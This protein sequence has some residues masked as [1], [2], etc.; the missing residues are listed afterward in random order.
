M[1]IDQI[2]QINHILNFPD[3]G[4][5]K[6]STF[7]SCLISLLFS[8][9]ETSSRAFAASA[10]K[11]DSYANARPDK[12]QGLMSVCQVQDVLLFFLKGLPQHQV[13][14]SQRGTGTAPGQPSVAGSQ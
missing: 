7:R 13:E 11:Y 12:A 6:H 9:F 8:L 3:T 2:I 5:S 1:F 4:F 10:S 14:A